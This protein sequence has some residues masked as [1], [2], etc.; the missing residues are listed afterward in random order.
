MTIRW[1]NGRRGDDVNDIANISGLTEA[2]PTDERRTKA[3]S[4]FEEYMRELALSPPLERVAALDKELDLI[5]QYAR[6]TGLFRDHEMLEFRIGRLVTRWRLGERLAK[7]MRKGGPGPGRGKKG[8]KGLV[9]FATLID[10][11]K[12][13]DPI[14]VEAQRIACLPPLELEAFCAR[15]RAEA[16][17]MLPTFAELLRYARPWWYQE[18]RR[19][20]HR[21]IARRAKLSNEPLGPFPLF[22]VDPPWK[23]EIYSDKGLER[24]PD[25]HYP[26]LSDEEII[27]F[28]IGKKTIP[29][30]ADRQAAM[31][32]W[33][34]SSNLHR[35]L[36][37]MQAWGFEFKTSAVWDKEK[38]GLGLVFRNQHE[39]LLYGTKGDMPGPQY[40]P[41]SVFRYPVGEHSA[42]PPQ[43]RA[44]IEKMYPD[45]DAKLRLELFARGE[46][47]G[48]M[49]YGLE[50]D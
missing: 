6:D 45:F 12:I 8:T 32:M 44:A 37:V 28:K 31:F 26:T 14:A 41:S 34:T 5:E 16:A 39:V 36:A 13:T 3:L 42:K 47:K 11:L 27:N 30:I 25:Q 20:K 35:A 24:T 49:T 4:R 18:S 21:D 17:G 33:C 48:W 2:Q 46:V 19:E 15:A 29:Q 10:Q 7:V 50:A 38:S 40:Q 9:G 22:Y 43:V 23:F 1:A